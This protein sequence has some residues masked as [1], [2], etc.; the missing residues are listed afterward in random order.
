MIG[1]LAG[2][3]AGAGPS[4]TAR[5]ELAPFL[6]VRRMTPFVHRELGYH[7]LM[8]GAAWPG[9]F[10]HG[11]GFCLPKGRQFRIVILASVAGVA[12][13]HRRWHRCSC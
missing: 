2:A 1:H 5:P 8:G 13:S 3:G 12:L 6:M 9:A 4:P 7:S 10:V 11:W